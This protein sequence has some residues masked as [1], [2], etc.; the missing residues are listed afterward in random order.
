MCRALGVAGVMAALLAPWARA[1]AADH[2]AQVL[3]TIEACTYCGKCETVCPYH[4]PVVSLL[5]RVAAGCRTVS[6]TLAQAGWQEQ[7]RGVQP[8]FAKPA[9][10]VREFMS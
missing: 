10:R 4:L 8:P 2:F 1:Q 6:E 9:G 7:Y 3:R 5:Q